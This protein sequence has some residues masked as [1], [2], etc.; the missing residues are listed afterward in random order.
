MQPLIQKTLKL[1]ATYKQVLFIF[2]LIVL[3]FLISLLSTFTYNLI[4]SPQSDSEQYSEDTYGNCNIM[5]IEI[6]GELYTYVPRDFEGN[7]LEGY[8][9]T[10]TSEDI[11]YLL[12]EAEY[13]DDEIQ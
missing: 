10:A 5:G 7:K 9:D 8:E 2:G 3:L 13:Y 4:A 1:I 12:D 6:R 11:L